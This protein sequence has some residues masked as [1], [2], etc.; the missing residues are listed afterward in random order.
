MPHWVKKRCATEV[1]SRSRSVG[2]KS[3]CV[4]LDRIAGRDVN[5]RSAQ[6]GW[7]QIYD[8]RAYSVV[9]LCNGGHRA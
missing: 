6:H 7:R 3:F 8:C 5:M 1:R 4:P 9:W 2:G